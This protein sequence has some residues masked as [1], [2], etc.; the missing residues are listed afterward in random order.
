[1]AIKH[2]DLVRLREI[3]DVV[4]DR[5]ESAYKDEWNDENIFWLEQSLTR[6]RGVSL[7]LGSVFSKEE[8]L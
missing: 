7:D 6:M 5:I 2:K 4:T 3:V 1:M 8:L